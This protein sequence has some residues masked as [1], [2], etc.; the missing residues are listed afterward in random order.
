MRWQWYQS[1]FNRSCTHMQV[2]LFHVHEVTLCKIK[3]LHTTSI[4]KIWYWSSTLPSSSFFFFFFGSKIFRETILC[5]QWLQAECWLMFD[6]PLLDVGG[7]ITL[8]DVAALLPVKNH[9]V[10]RVHALHTLNRVPTIV[11]MSLSTRYL[12]ILEFRPP[13]GYPMCIL[14]SVSENRQHWM[15]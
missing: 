14:S 6:S 7:V 11:V 3:F 1:Y 2:Y 15:H 9:E 10:F 12:L 13:D 5:H 8:L 4:D